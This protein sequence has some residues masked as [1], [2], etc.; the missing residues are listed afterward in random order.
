MSDN[1]P[2]TVYAK[3]YKRP[4]YQIDHVDMTFELDS[5]NTKATAEMQVRREN[6]V[7]DGTPMWLDG[8][9]LTLAG[10]EING[11]P[12]DE[13]DYVLSEEGLMLL[14]PPKDFTLTVRS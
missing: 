8:D 6:G 9:E 13:K 2:K 3:D 7:A 4:D 12:V 5:E 10:L 14:N 11:K 1:T